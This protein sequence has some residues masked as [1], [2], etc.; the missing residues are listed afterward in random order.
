MDYSSIDKYIALAR[1]KGQSDEQ[2]KSSLTSAGWSAE[3]VDQRL[4]GGG[5]LPPP[6]VSASGPV[7]GNSGPTISSD[8]KMMA[9]SFLTPGVIV[10]MKWSVIGYAIYRGVRFLPWLLRGNWRA[11]LDS[12]IGWA[13]GSIIIGA[14]IGFVL[15]RYWP[16]IQ[17]RLNRY[18][19]LR[20]W[21]KNLFWFVFA[22][23]ILNMIYGV[24]ALG[25]F[26]SLFSFNFGFGLN[27]IFRSYL[28]ALILELVGAFVFGQIMHKKVEPLVDRS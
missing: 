1:G 28:F 7:V 27:Y 20:W 5:D 25:A 10:G 21:T 17:S 19:Y 16:K 11:V 24:F 4:S 26:S 14:I 12:L 9:K 22:P 2:I 23:A 6:P 18:R 13:I 3:I 15:V 8:P